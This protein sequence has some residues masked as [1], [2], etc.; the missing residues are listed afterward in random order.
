MKNLWK[1]LIKKINEIIIIKNNNYKRSIKLL[2]IF[3]EENMNYLFNFIK[4]FFI[5]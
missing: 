1:K 5:Y 3:D 4:K 2:L